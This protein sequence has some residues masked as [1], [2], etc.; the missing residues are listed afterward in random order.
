MR[1]SA[2]WF[3]LLATVLAFVPARANFAQ[4]QGAPIAAA[5][6][7]AQQQAL[8]QQLQA[9]EDQIAVQQQELNVLGRQKNTLANKIH[10]MAVKQASRN[11]QIRET[12]AKLDDVAAQMDQTRQDI[13]ANLVT[14]S[15]LRD[16]M[17]QILALIDQRD[18]EP[19][20]LYA[21]IDQ[22]NLSSALTEVERD[23]ELS[24]S[25]TSTLD[26]AQKVA[27]DL[28]AQQQKLA[29]EQDDAQQLLSIQTLQKSQLASDL[30]DQN[31]LLVATK[32]K[33]S[34]YQA[35]LA[36]TTKQAADI[37]SRIYQLLGVSTQIT[38]GQAVQAA[39]WVSQQTGVPT[40]FL[41]AIL[42]QES[43]LGKN[44]GTCNRPG[45]PPDKSWRVVMKPD[46]DQQPFVQITQQLGRDTDVTPVS[47]PMHDRYG[48]RIGWGG[49]MGPAQFI[50][51]TWIG[52]MP[53]VQAVT[54][55]VPD[56]WD[57]RDAFVAA[58]LKLA[59]DGAAG[60]TRQDE[61]DAAMRYFSG[62]TNTR[63][64][65]YGDEVLATMDTYQADIN[66]LNQ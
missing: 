62:S 41:L 1:R 4:A 30:Q 58:G 19:Q 12:N 14:Q 25:L 10:Q 31:D 47:C 6:V 56:P 2:A 11:L 36:D 65:F 64:R 48:N 42:T 52:W 15:D 13:A 38:F 35:Q 39:N 33:E 16:Q 9:L 44:V 46:R 51:S 20:W 5:D 55:S 28:N 24:S 18:R 27:D 45:D 49:A 17:S 63:Y 32:G 23:T 43:N 37:R 66:D 50:P 29:Q 26:K 22:G 57:I 59:A 61:W 3:L 8:E 40:A 7:A 60:G 53:R 54:G 21:V 34:A